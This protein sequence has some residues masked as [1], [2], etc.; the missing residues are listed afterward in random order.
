M[1]KCPGAGVSK[2]FIKSVSDFE[3]TWICCSDIMLGQGRPRWWEKQ[4][5]PAGPD[6]KWDVTG[7]FNRQ[8]PEPEPDDAS[9]IGCGTANANPSASL[10]PHELP[11]IPWMIK[12]EVRK[13][14][15]LPNRVFATGCSTSPSCPESVEVVVAG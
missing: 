2:L 9:H 5:S 14:H 8:E 4:A 6:Q 13:A 1:C 7:G 15:Q 3:W 11:N 12:M 10:T